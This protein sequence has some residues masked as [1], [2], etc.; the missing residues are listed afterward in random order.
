MN[1]LPLARKRYCSVEHA[2]DFVVL[3]DVLSDD[4]KRPCQQAAT[5]MCCVLSDLN[6]KH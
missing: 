3:F 6:S 1:Y 4:K 2:K 5:L